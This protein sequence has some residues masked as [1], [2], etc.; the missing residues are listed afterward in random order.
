[1]YRLYY[2]LIFLL[3][4]KFRDKFPLKH[5]TNNSFLK[6][7]LENI[8]ESK[9]QLF[10]DLWVQWR[11]EKVELISTSYLQEAY[12]IEVGA[13]HPEVLSNSLFL[14]NKNKIATYLIE[15][16]PEQCK[17]FNN[18]NAK[19][20]NIAIT[21]DEG[22]VELQMTELREFSHLATINNVHRLAKSSSKSV[23]VPSDSLNNVII[24]NVKEMNFLYLSIDIEGGEL[25]ALQSINFDMYRPQYITVE[26]N[27][28]YDRKKIKELL[29]SK[30]YMKCEEQPLFIWDDWYV[31]K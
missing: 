16:N 23:L 11:I 25:E 12:Q 8:G 31:K 4:Y 24:K 5:I 22:T 9:S 21:R 28:R 19:V 6:Y 15:A 2:S 18:R 26:H 14:E 3:L 17:L 1:M 7:I 10:Q 27:F 30:G 13:Y 20:L 29:E